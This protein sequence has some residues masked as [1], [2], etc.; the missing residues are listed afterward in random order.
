MSLCSFYNGTNWHCAVMNLIVKDGLSLSENHLKL[1]TVYG[2]SALSLSTL[3]K[4]GIGFKCSHTILTDNSYSGCS[5]FSTSQQIVRQMDDM[6][7]HTDKWKTRNSEA[8]CFSKGLVYQIWTKILG[9]NKL[10]MRW[11]PIC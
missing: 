10:C 7:S 5:E 4:L 3:K 2:D 1:V 11:V 8:I 6:V 9:I